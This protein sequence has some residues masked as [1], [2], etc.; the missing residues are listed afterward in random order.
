MLHILHVTGRYLPYIG[1]SSLRLHNL[2]KP[3]V[4]AFEGEMHILVSLTNLNGK[5][6]YSKPV[7]PYE[8]IQGIHVHRVPNCFMMV[9]A[10]RKICRQYNIDIIHAHNLRAAFISCLG[11]IKKP[12]VVEYHALRQWSLIKDKLDR[13]IA[14]RPDSIIVLSNNARKE[15]AKKYN[16]PVSKIVPILNGVDV[17]KFTPRPKNPYILEKYHFKENDII[18]GYLG[19]FYDWQGVHNIL[20][21]APH[22]LK[23]IPDVKFFLVGGGPAFEAMRKQVCE[24]GITDSVIFADKVPPE[25]VPD[26]FSVMDVFLAP[27]P[28]TF[29]TETTVPLKIL[30]VMAM[31]IP[32]VGT[33]VGGFTEVIRNGETGVLVAPGDTLRFVDAVISLI[34]SAPKRLEIA[35]NA[36]S[37][38]ENQTWKQAS[39]RLCDIYYQITSRRNTK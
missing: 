4:N 34:D 25:Q 19:T 1:G 15:V 11:L 23:K 38:I 37:R 29:E 3:I 33:G 7:K 27:R 12:L 8:I 2:I 17:D 20:D 14:K 30:E 5:K 32:L 24:L 36:R 6:V 13:I 18:L 10:L 26:F 31:G 9:S 39:A 35:R 22:I 21:A 28:S 16:I